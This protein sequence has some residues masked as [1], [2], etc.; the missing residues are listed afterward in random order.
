[1]NGLHP[2]HKRSLSSWTPLC[3][4]RVQ[5]N[6]DGTASKGQNWSPFTLMIPLVFSAHA[7]SLFPHFIFLLIISAT[8]FLY[9]SLFPEHFRWP[10][11]GAY[12]ECSCNPDS[13][14]RA[15]PAP[16]AWLVLYCSHSSSAQRGVCLFSTLHTQAP[17]SCTF[18]KGDYQPNTSETSSEKKNGHCSPHVIGTT[19]H[20]KTRVNA[21]KGLIPW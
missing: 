1:M 11:S 17:L 14:L 13:L 6:P 10:L 19:Q 5:R 7:L 15:A 16:R 8:A 21:C 2:D 20:S 18:Y 9:V 3:H 12:Q 4:W